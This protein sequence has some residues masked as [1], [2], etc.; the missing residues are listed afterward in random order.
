MHRGFGGD[1]RHRKG[2]GKTLAAVREITKLYLKN[3]YRIY[4][5][6][7]LAVPHI[8]I[9]ANDLIKLGK[10]PESLKHSIIFADEIQNIFNSIGKGTANLVFN[11]IQ[12]QTRKGDTHLFWT[13]QRIK[14]TDNRIVDDAELFHCSKW[15]MDGTRCFDSEDRCHK[16]HFIKVINIYSKAGYAFKVTE[17]VV[18]LYDTS[19]VVPL[20]FFQHEEIRKGLREDQGQPGTAGPAI[21]TNAMGNSLEVL[22]IGELQRVLGKRAII[23][24][25]AR[26]NDANISL[27]DVEV[28][29]EGKLHLFDV[30]GSVHKEKGNMRLTT[31]HKDWGDMIAV[32]NSRHALPWLAFRNGTGWKTLEISRGAEWIRLKGK[33]TMTKKRMGTARDVQGIF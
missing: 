1:P 6:I 23:R 33:I 22:F 16:E 9:S 21:E 14:N 17:Y 13:S 20:A 29:H 30:V 26:Y 11:F 25:N 18:D 7:W 15:H 4:S 5:N 3:H 12:N 10:D 19:E 27:Y 32:A 28:E 2:N 24:H 31:D 8:L